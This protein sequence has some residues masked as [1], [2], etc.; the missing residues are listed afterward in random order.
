MD[1][2]IAWFGK[3]FDTFGEKITKETVESFCRH[4]KRLIDPKVTMKYMYGIARKIALESPSKSIV[5][6]GLTAEIEDL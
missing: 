1:D 3:I 5:K 6:L 2:E 4:E